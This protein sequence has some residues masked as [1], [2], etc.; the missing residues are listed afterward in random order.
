VR[1]GGLGGV[2]APVCTP[3]DA[4]TG[5]V[6]PVLLR[7]ATR[8][9]LDA[10]LDGIVVA[11]STGEGELLDE[12]EKVRL[13]EYLRDVVPDDRWLVCGTGA[14]STRAALR[15]A[16]A[17]G[18]A[19][20]DAVLVRPPSYFGGIVP[21]AAFA[22]HYA[23]IADESP[24]PVIIYNIPRYAHVALSDT[25][26]RA[27]ADHERILG[28]KE[29]S[30]DLKVFSAFRAAAP[31]L[32][33]LMGAGHLFYPALEMGAAGGILAMA[34]F[35]A[36]PCVRLYRAFRDEDRPTA[37]A[38][39]ERLSPLAR[40]IVGGLGPAGI[41]AAMEVV[42]LPCGPVRPPLLDVDARARARIVDL[43]TAAGLKA[44]A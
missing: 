23:R 17:A 5:D 21:A 22:Y 40:E 35:A 26:L 32:T 24:V 25:V 10:G 1:P 38:L 19:G 29:S 39:Q 14:E 4:E 42:G 11:G 37:G 20:A 34:T 36:E 30:G 31:R 6:A 3:F 27:V 2:L 9:L 43:L 28:F 12:S 18:A 15:A 13:V 44:A 7:S 33:A 8:A 16:Q 41:K